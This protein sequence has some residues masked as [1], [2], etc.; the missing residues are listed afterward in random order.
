VKG[1]DADD[2]E[3]KRRKEGASLLFFLRFPCRVCPTG[4]LNV[5]SAL[6]PGFPAGGATVRSTVREKRGRQRDRRR[7]GEADRRR[8]EGK[9]TWRMRRPPPVRI[10]AAGVSVTGLPFP[11]AAPQRTGDDRT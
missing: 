5:P 7:K 4:C 6:D 2:T 10:V 11:M 1:T 8:K 9:W 3:G